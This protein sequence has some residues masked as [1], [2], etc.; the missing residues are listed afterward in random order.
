MILPFAFITFVHDTF[1]DNSCT[2][3]QMNF[4]I[5]DFLQVLKLQGCQM[6]PGGGGEEDEALLNC[7]DADCIQN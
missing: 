1:G 6:K 5:G 2:L 4:R 7:L 3:C